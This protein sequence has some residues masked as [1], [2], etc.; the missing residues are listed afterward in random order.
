MNPSASARPAPARAAFRAARTCVRTSVRIAAATLSLG[1]LLTG[2]AAA[3]VHDRLPGD[4]AGGAA[5]LPAAPAIGED[6]AA[7]VYGGD[8]APAPGAP[9]APAPAGTA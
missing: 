3:L 8:P 6:G 7:P 2:P 9:L 1:A 5:S 4:D